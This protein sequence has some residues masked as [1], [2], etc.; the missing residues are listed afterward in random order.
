LDNGKWETTFTVNSKKIYYDDSGK[1]KEVDEKKNL[2]DVGLFGE[3][4]TNDDG[5]T[6]KNPFFFELKWLST[7]DNTF[8]IITDEKPSKVGIDPYNK[9]IDR[10]S[11]DNL[12]SVEE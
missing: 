8:T 9:L 1:E 10:N 6:I 7:G 3:D 2:V 5:I 4:E 12:K 11:D